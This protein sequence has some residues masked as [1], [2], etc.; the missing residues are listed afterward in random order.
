MKI[1]NAETAFIPSEKIKDYL[2]SLS[3]P[4]GRFKAVFFNSLGYSSNNWEQLSND[5]RST[6][7][8]DADKKEK[9]EFGQKYEINSKIVGPFK[10][11]AHITTVWIILTD[12]DY[13]RFVT[14]YPV[15]EK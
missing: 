10:K 3:H 12:K 13:P 14:A 4:V 5:I 11:T 1:P 6:L 2:L 15:D 8:H 9:S 7:H